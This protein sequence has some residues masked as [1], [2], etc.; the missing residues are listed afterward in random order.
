MD[1]FLEDIEKLKVK[2]NEQGPQFS[3]RGEIFA[4]V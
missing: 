1:K 4:E 2:Y 3:G